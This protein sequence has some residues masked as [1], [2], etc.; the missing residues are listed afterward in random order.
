M[1]REPTHSKLF[2]P[3]YCAMIALGLFNCLF[4][5]SSLATIPVL[6]D[7]RGVSEAAA[8]VINMLFPLAALFFR[9]YT[10]RIGAR[11]SSRASIGF[12][13]I[14]L[15]VSNVCLN[16]APA[17]GW[18]IPV[19]VAQG[20]AICYIAGVIASLLAE[21]VPQDR[22]EE[23]MGYFSIAIPA[24]SFF[25]P[26]LCRILIAQVGYEKMLYG[27]SLL[28]LIPIV[29]SFRA[30]LP[31]LT[32]AKPAARSRKVGVIE[33]KAVPASLLLMGAAMAATCTV[34][35]LPLYAEHYHLNNTLSF[36]LIAGVG[37]F[38]IRIVTT[39]FKKDLPG[40]YAIPAATVVL[41]SVLLLLPRTDS[42]PLDM[43]M[44]F[45]YGMAVGVVQPYFIAMALKAADPSRKSV[46]T[47]TYYIFNDIG[48]T[49]GGILWGYIAQ[50]VSYYAV[51]VTAA[52]IN[53]ATFL[54]WIAVAGRRSAARPVLTDL[55]AF[56]PKHEELKK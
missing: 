6:M 44:G 7:N 17:V 36:Y 33:R 54:G 46:A 16:W 4:G 9:T 39:V 5:Q 1:P 25:G 13:F 38:V 23:G 22:F 52:L 14:V 29:L 10:V 47:V 30:R 8:A 56:S 3:A 42:I 21:T 32:P 24:M 2:T 15:A 20:L 41:V 19:R 35:F 12:C 34:S 31:Q 51:F 18:V 48:T 40:R 37:V 43:L 49:A 28:M 55:P 27:I 53:A 26:A 11:V 50:Y 45:P